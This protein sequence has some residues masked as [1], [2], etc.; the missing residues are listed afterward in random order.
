MIKTYSYNDFGDFT[1]QQKN[2]KDFIL[3]ELK[4]IHDKGISVE[5]MIRLNN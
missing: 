4:K 2:D 3:K 1:Y 5:L